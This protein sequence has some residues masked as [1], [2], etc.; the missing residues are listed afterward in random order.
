[1]PLAVYR[2]A[3]HNALRRHPRSRAPSAKCAADLEVN[4]LTTPQVVGFAA[5]VLMTQL[6]TVGIDNFSLSADYGTSKL[7]LDALSA[8]KA[9]IFPG[10]E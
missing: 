3:F 4:R 5:H 10:H 8:A 1:M 7:K 9:P 2:H 6:M